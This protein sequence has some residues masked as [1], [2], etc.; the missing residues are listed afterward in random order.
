MRDGSLHWKNRNLTGQ[1]FGALVVVRPMGSDGRKMRWEFRC[2]CGKTVIKVGAD[3]TKEVKRGGTPNCG[4]LSRQLVG[5][6][7]TTHGKSKHPLHHVWAGMRGRCERPTDPAWKNYG[8]RGIKVCKRWAV[9]Q[10][11]WDDMSST[12]RPGLSLERKDNNK[13]YSASNCKWATPKAQALNKRNSIGLDL[14]IMSKNTGISRS[15]LYYR[16]RN[17]WPLDKLQVPPNATNRYGTYSIAARSNA[18]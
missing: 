17:G 6:A 12:Y 2:D 14:A 1:T 18:S 3:V 7:N 10:N 8:G 4:C 15:T 11:F 13:G 9:F 16:W 5:I